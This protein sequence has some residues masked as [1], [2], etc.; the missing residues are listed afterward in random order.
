VAN[1]SSRKPLGA[2]V[3]AGRPL[4]TLGA[5]CRAEPSAPQMMG[6]EATREGGAAEG[7]PAGLMQAR[8]TAGNAAPGSHLGPAA[9]PTRTSTSSCAATKTAV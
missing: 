5:P 1:S 3:A 6:P 2:S 7:R 8:V 9:A 4:T